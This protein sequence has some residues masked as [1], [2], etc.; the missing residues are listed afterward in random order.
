MPSTVY[1]EAP[2]KT[3]DLL[4]LKWLLRSSGCKIVSTWHD[5]PL[6]PA[7]GLRSHLTWPRLEELKLCDTLVVVCGDIEEIPLELAIITGFATAHNL[8]VI[9]IGLP[10]EPLD[11]CRNVHFFPTL[12]EFRE[13]L[14]LLTNV[15]PKTS[16][17]LLVA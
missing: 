5:E 4:T 16:L 6:L 10:L 8:R 3:Q 7:N 1:L 14:G 2:A 13:Q 12:E 15:Q 11:H 9:W 17:D